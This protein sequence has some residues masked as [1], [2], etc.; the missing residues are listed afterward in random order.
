MFKEKLP[1]PVTS[2]PRF[3][4]AIQSA[5]I[6]LFIVRTLGGA[7]PRFRSPVAY[8]IIQL[9]S[10]QR[11]QANVRQI[12]LIK[13]GSNISQIKINGAVAMK[14]VWGIRHEA[15]DHTNHRRIRWRL[16]GTAREDVFF[17]E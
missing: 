15:E 5:C 11:R 4:Q 12:L 2:S 17:A 10:S 7:D 6:Y 1:P 8:M 16:G 9:L 13:Q 14:N 3:P